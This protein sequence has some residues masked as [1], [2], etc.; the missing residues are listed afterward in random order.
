M[1][2]SY[3]GIISC[4]ATALLVA[5]CAPSFKQYRSEGQKL[6]AEGRYNAALYQL[7]T[8]RNMVPEHSWNL[9]DMAQCHMALAEEAGAR[10]DDR[11]ELRELDRAIACYKRALRSFPGMPTALRGMNHALEVRGDSD[12]ALESARWA[13]EIVGPSAAQQLFLAREYAE[14][15]D[16]DQALLCYRQAV[17]MEPTNPTAHW[18]LG[19]FYLTLDRRS[20]GVEHLQTAYRLDPTRMYIAD[21]LEL[22][23]VE[24][25]TPAHLEP[26]LATGK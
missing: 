8:A 10:Q 5:G 19:M 18:A 2:R 23:G 4:A 14:R 7:R 21:R 24:V 15:G 1:L 12:E 3:P 25:D 13:S 16:A 9:C 22:M 20:D 26:E 11:A 6:M 17:A